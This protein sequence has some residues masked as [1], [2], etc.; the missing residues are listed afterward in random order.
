M[1]ILGDQKNNMQERV[2]WT[3]DADYY[4][5]QYLISA[6]ELAVLRAAGEQ[7]S[8]ERRL[9]YDALYDW[10]RKS[11]RYAACFNEELIRAISLDEEVFWDDVVLGRLTDTY[12]N[13]QRNYGE[14]FSMAGLS[15]E[16]FIG[17]LTCFHEHIRFAFMRN[18]LATFELM[19]AFKK[20]AQVAVDIVTEVYNHKMA[21]TLQEQNDSL[22]ELSTPVAQIWEGVLLL[23]LVGFIDSKR[24]QDIMQ[25]M[26]A[27][28][29][30]TQSKFFILDISGV[31]IVDTAVANHLIKMSKAAKLMG[32][33]CI[34]SGIS[35]PIAQ[36]IVEL[37]ID[38]DE[39]RTTSS[40]RDA[41]RLAIQ[42][43]KE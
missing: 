30:E 1:D 4:K 40:M 6:E 11:E 39:I 31:A 35:G 7:I 29:G 8:A 22:R 20:F 25:R 19:T 43:Q 27:E 21:C 41:L 23:P 32:C 34:I 36:T 26:L 38:I 5:E 2:V 37:G 10:M 13:T 28:V 16:S 17:I 24:A 9:V 15:L 14:H 42:E 18:G 33:N 3:K 12:V